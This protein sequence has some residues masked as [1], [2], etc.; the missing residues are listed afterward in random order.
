MGKNIRGGNKA[1]RQKNSSADTGRRQL[2][3]KDNT[4]DSSELYGKVLKRLGGSPARILVN[5]EDGVE[6]NCVIRGKFQKRIW[7]NPGDYVVLLYNR[8]SSDRSGEIAH[9]YFPHE[10]AQLISKGE[11][12]ENRFKD[13]D[14]LNDDFGITFAKEDLTKK[15]DNYDDWFATPTNNNKTFIAN[16]D[17]D[18]EE[19]DEFTF[20]DI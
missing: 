6:R 2:H 11:I 1:K 7:I 8:G 9:K 14:E 5:C 12:D 20:D 18:D 3:T 16:M 19:E 17:N 10:V 13:S 15:E 4:A